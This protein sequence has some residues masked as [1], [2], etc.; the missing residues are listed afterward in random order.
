MISPSTIK[1]FNDFLVRALK[2]GQ[3]GRGMLVPVSQLINLKEKE[4]R[5]ATFRY[6]DVAG[7]CWHSILVAIE[8]APKIH[9]RINLE[10]VMKMLAIH[11]L[12]EI[13]MGDTVWP[14]PKP[15]G[16]KEKDLL[17][18]AVSGSELAEEYKRLFH[19][20]EECQT[21]EANFAT[22][23]DRLSA[24]LVLLS[25]GDTMAPQYWKAYGITRKKA[26]ERWKLVS[27]HD[28]FLTAYWHYL[29]DQ[30]GQ[31]IGWAS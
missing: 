21:A 11:D 28:E 22:A 23:V 6:E 10:H 9:A 12:G 13:I 25:T 3:V 15:S 5:D 30:I 4:G 2:L 27:S 16:I 29:L 20:F 26:E 18:Q 14:K 1:P 7:H 19:E 24:C 8:L 31:K 17:A